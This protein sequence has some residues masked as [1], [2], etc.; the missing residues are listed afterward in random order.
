ME[1][2]KNKTVLNKTSVYTN[3][4]YKIDFNKIAINKTGSRKIAELENTKNK[5]IV[6]TLKTEK[7]LVLV[8]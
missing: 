5:T 8:I 3:N 1:K 7:S 4:I 2:Y 6:T